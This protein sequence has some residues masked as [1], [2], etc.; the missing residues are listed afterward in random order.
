MQEQVIKVLKK[1]SFLSRYSEICLEFSDHKNIK[2]PLF[3]S[4]KEILEQIDDNFKYI[5]AERVFL[6]TIKVS[7]ELTIRILVSFSHGL[8]EFHL[9]FIKNEEWILYDRLDFLG[10]LIDP[11]YKESLGDNCL[12][13]TTNDED[14]EQ[15]LKKVI[16]LINE[17]KDEFKIKL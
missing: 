4:I 8:F 6:K 10:N 17:F 9:Q 16:A 1:I 15:I 5:K 11:E 13:M 12:P 7:D 2:T 3:K 14:T